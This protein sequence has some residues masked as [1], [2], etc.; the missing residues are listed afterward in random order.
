VSPGP[1]EAPDTRLDRVLSGRGAVITGASQ[2]LGRAIAAR[3]VGAGASV[4]LVARGQPPLE[5]ARAELASLADGP[6]Q[7]VGI[8]VGDVSDP[9]ACA[10][11]AEAARELLPNLCILVNNAG[12]YGPIGPLEEVDWAAWEDAVRINLFGTVLMCRAVIPLLRA[13]GYGKIVN[14]SGG[15]ATAPLP[16]FTAYAAAKAA[17]VRL[18]ETL[19]VELRD[20]GIDVNA[21]APGSLN[22]R[23]LDQVLA[24]GPG[25]AG[26][27]FYRRALQQRDDGGVPLD[28]AAALVTFLASAASDGITGRLLSAVWDDWAG[29]AG[30]A[31]AL[32]GSDLY[33][34]RRITPDD[35]PG[36]R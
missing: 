5:E 26:E 27:T 3:F 4:L 22:T 8:A 30:R 7:R 12:V 2:G 6:G 18:T 32:A 17:V 13:R 28:R 15:G 20:A 33:T 35:R 31:A 34:L 36:P 1:P 9:A 10:E 23:L 14:L 29:L 16:R 24:A 21:V 19:A 25:A 11:V